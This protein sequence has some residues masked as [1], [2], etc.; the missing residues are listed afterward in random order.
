MIQPVNFFEHD[1]NFC[2]SS[3]YKNQ[4]HGEYL[5][6]IS[7]LFISFIG[8]Y[9]LMKPY[10]YLFLY[11]SLV[12]NGITSFFYHWYN[13]IG[14]G[15]LDRMSM[16]LIALS[17]T[18]IFLDHIIIFIKLEKWKKRKQ[19]MQWIYI[20]VTS[21]FTILLTISGLHMEDVFNG[22]F[23]LFLGSL[24]IYM[25]LVHKHHGNL[26]IPKEVVQ[27]GWNGSF[28][29]LVSGCFWIFTE[30]LC[31]TFPFVK[32]LFGHV[33]WHIFV[34][35]GGYLL[36]LIPKYLTAREEVYAIHLKY[37]LFIPYLEII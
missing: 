25:V 10:P 14:W 18:Q 16:V 19:M 27:I 33:W 15:L 30:T 26:T 6:S 7:S 23:A 3:I 34:S 21:Y 28:M 11:S 5:N 20:F 12:V 32:Y 1:H 8:V 17:S 24:F 35:Y 4:Q 31:T 36:S 29:I 22:L 13:N 37:D 9:G 2:E